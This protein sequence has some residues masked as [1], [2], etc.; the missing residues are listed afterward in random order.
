MKPPIRTLILWGVCGVPTIVGCRGGSQETAPAPPPMDV[1]VATPITKHVVEWDEYTGRLDAIDFVEIRARVGGYLQ[2]IHFTEG[3]V[4]KKGDLLFVIDPRPFVAEV[5]RAEAALEEAKSHEAELKASFG[6]AV[7]GK[8]E[9]EANLTLE[10]RNYRRAEQL[11]ANNSISREEFDQREAQ[12]IQAR[13][14][15]ESATARIAS[16]EAAVAAATAAI[17][18]AAA[19]LETAQ[20]NL[21]YTELRAPI[22][23]R[24]SRR[25]I[26][27]GNLVS[28]GSA[29]STLLTTI[30]S[31]DPIHCYFDADESA[32]LKYAR[33][34]ES[35]KRA[36]SRDVKNPI[37]LALADEKPKFPHSGHMDFVDNRLDP[38]TGT[39]RGRAILR[40]PNFLLTPGL[41]AQVRLPGSAPYDAILIPDRAIGSDQSE[42]FVYVVGDDGTVR[43]Q[44]I[45]IGPIVHGLRV[46]RDGLKGNEKIIVGGIQRVR[47]GAKVNATVEQFAIDAKDDDG[48]PDT[49]VP[50]PEPEWIQR[51]S[52]S[53]PRGGAYPTGPPREPA[54]TET[55][56]PSPPTPGQ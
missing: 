44:N 45:K 55:P 10:Q 49:F 8:T 6:E 34:A 31:L 35:G 15:V 29:D 54:P 50:V 1:T 53:L 20:L 48:L 42:K 38:N 26:T 51:D 46:I 12:L 39:M 43:R 19:A 23:G 3:Q 37:Y 32:F 17:G 13:A 28:G 27:E 16:A 5:K 18:T 41:F 7:A 30:V 40:N 33:L 21:G 47:P 14:Q 56:S 22:S 11:V 24:V 2:S 9:A 4:V 36:S 25:E 52:G